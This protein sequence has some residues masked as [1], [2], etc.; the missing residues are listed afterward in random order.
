M[1]SKLIVSEKADTELVF[2]LLAQGIE[3]SSLVLF[4]SLCVGVM[5]SSGD[6]K[7]GSIGQCSG[8]WVNI[9]D[10]S[11]WKILPKGASVVLTQT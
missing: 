8:R 6:H 11:V 3:D 7:W 2:P 1:K 4:T 10:K 9:T 5:L